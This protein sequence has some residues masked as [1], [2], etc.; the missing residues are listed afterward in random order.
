MCSMK[1]LCSDSGAFTGAGAVRNVQYAVCRVQ[2]CE[3]L[4]VETGRVK[5]KF[6]LKIY[7]FKTDSPS[8]FNLDSLR[9]YIFENLQGATKF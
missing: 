2:C 3:E 4:A 5:F 9:L 8:E 7:L 1:C 6:Y